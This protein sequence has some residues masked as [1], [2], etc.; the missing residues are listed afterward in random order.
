MS[1]LASRG[2]E[3]DSVSLS[4]ARLSNGSPGGYVAWHQHRPGRYQKHHKSGLTPVATS[5][6][7]RP[8]SQII[9]SGLPALDDSLPD[10][11]WR[12]GAVTEILSDPDDDSALK[13]V[14]PALAT[15]SQEKKWLCWI[16]PPQFLDKFKL[17]NAGI[18]ISR[19]LLVHPRASTNGLWLVE[20]VLRAGTCSAVLTWMTGGNA[21][22]ADKCDIDTAVILERLQLAAEVGGSTGFVFRDQSYASQDSPVA[23]RLLLKKQQQI[24]RLA[25]LKSQNTKFIEPQVLKFSANRLSRQNGN[26]QNNSSKNKDHL[27]QTSR[28]HSNQKSLSENQQLSLY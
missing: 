28:T 8:Q 23:T 20:Q 12:R 16:G 2:L 15:I 9:A 10:G 11:G 22:D 3:S 5:V 21:S 25:V 7:N 27:R 1:R 6:I 26:N 4:P 14:L 19:V 13:L 17:A 24:I 18:D